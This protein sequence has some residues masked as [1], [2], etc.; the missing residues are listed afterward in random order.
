MLSSSDTGHF[1]SWQHMILKQNKEKLEL[2]SSI[3]HCFKTYS[4]LLFLDEKWKQA[5]FCSCFIIGYFSLELYLTTNI[6]N[7]LVLD[8]QMSSY[9]VKQR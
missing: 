5:E 9:S 2:S 7:P 3:A 4:Y 1:P 6:V 8:Q